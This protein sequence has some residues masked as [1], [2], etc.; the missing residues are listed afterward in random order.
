MHRFVVAEEPKIEYD[1][2]FTDKI[3][4]EY[5]EIYNLDTHRTFLTVVGS[6][7]QGYLPRNIA[8]LLAGDICEMLNSK[9][10]DKNINEEWFEAD[11]KARIKFHEE[12]KK[13]LESGKYTNW[14]EHGT[15]VE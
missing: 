7:R 4:F 8:P 1:D 14:N 10:I 9:Y 5:W 15:G 11:R 12:Q 3:A 2:I 6:D 13:L